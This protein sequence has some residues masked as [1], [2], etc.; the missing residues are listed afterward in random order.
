[1][2]GSGARFGIGLDARFGCS[3][4]ML[5]SDDR[6]G[7]SVQMTGSGCSVRYDRFRMIG[8]GCSVRDARFGMMVRMLG[9][10]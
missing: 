7:C 3:V 5:G 1:M 2:L 10:V 9:S 4:R 8:S 6:F